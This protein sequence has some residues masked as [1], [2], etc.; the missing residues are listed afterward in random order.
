VDVSIAVQRGEVGI[1]SI[2]YRGVTPG[3]RM[4]GQPLHCL[5][6]LIGFHVLERG[7]FLGALGVRKFTLSTLLRDSVERR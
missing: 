3:S 1:V 5:H 2:Q 6:D 7:A 4:V